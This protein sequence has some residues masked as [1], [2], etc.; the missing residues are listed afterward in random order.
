MIQVGGYKD[1]S[2]LPWPRGLTRPCL[3][4]QVRKSAFAGEFSGTGKG[5]GRTGD[6][7][8]PLPA[9]GCSDCDALVRVVAVRRGGR[10]AA[11]KVLRVNSPVFSRFSFFKCADRVFCQEHLLQ[12]LET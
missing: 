2:A 5:S 11:E 3:G 9:L 4:G 10:A 7:R 6:P 1:R 8:V 12:I